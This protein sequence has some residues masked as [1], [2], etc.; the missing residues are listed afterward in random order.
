MEMVMHLLREFDEVLPLTSFPR[1]DSGFDRRARGEQYTAGRRRGVS[2]MS[3]SLRRPRH[4]R[5]RRVSLMSEEC[6]LPNILSL[7]LYL[8]VEPYVFDV[9]QTISTTVFER[10]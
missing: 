6:L 5:I 8:N 9:K 1:R 2:H 3:G 7:C 4:R 10:W